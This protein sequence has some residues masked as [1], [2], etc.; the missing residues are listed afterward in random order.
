[1][2]YQTLNGNWVMNEKGTEKY[3]DAAIPGSVMSTLILQRRI[4]D[5]FYRLNEYNAREI[6]RKD[7]FF[8]REFEVLP[9]L[10][11]SS[12]LGGCRFYQE[13]KG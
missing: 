2:I 11:N 12:D 3:F 10:L 6:S 13:R 9:E 7:F 5:P 4:E 1:M 8:Y